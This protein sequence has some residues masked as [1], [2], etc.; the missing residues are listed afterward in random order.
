MYCYAENSGEYEARAT[1]LIGSDST[2]AILK[3]SSKAGLIFDSQ[4]PQVNYF[5]YFLV[6][7]IFVLYCG[8]EYLKNKS[9]FLLQG[10]EGGLEKIQDLEDAMIRT[11][12]D[13]ISEEK[14]QAPV[15]TVPLSNLDSLREGESAHFEARLTPTDDPNLKVT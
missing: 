6:Y 15:F 10:M 14:R 9:Y 12:E 1:N 11:R 8:I 4:L 5:S 7:F 13:K 3:C 2:K